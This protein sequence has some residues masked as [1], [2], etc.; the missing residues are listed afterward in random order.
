MEDNHL[1]NENRL[2]LEQA[3]VIIGDLPDDIYTHKEIKPFFSSAGQHVRHIMNFYDCFF[4]C[5]NGRIDYDQRTREKDVEADPVVAVKKI[6]TLLT[7]FEKDIDPEKE[8]WSKNDDSGGRDPNSAFSRSTFGRELQ[9]LSSHTV[10]HYAMI[11]YIL[12]AQGVTTPE[13]FGVA[14]STLIHWHETGRLTS[15]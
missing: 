14:A 12:N 13:T 1:I 7:A 4:A 6:E 8:V 3:A 11:A 15:F 2:L 10:H 9:F 5:Q